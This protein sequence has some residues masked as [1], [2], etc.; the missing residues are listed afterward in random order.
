VIHIG[1]TAFF[2]IK[3]NCIHFLHL[4]VELGGGNLLQDKLNKGREEAATNNRG[5]KKRP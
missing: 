3:I 4:T 5:G 1:N 2:V